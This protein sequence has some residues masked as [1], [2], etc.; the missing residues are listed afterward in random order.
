MHTYVAS[1]EKQDPITGEPIITE[2]IDV[3]S[4][5]SG[6][7]SGRDPLLGPLSDLYT[8]AKAWNAGTKLL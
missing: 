6:A 3:G 8:G 1:K 7:M 5:G 4:N 2:T